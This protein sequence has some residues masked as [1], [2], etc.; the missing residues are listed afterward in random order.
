MMINTNATE[1]SA[2]ADFTVVGISGRFRTLS[3]LEWKY[4]FNGKNDRSRTASVC[5][6]TRKVVASDDFSGTLRWE[7]CAIRLVENVTE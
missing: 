7:G 6:I 2:K 4:I 3:M 5:G 1:P